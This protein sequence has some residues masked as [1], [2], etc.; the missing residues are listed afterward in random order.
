MLLSRISFK[1]RIQAL[2]VIVVIIASA[3]LTAFYLYQEKA[4]AAERA[5]YGSLTIKQAFNTI[6][7]DLEH[8]FVFRA[9]A[10][11]N[12]PEVKTYIKSR[13]NEEL[14]NFVL[15]RYTLLRN[16]NPYLKIMQF[17]AYDG[18][19]ILRMHRKNEFGDDIASKRPMLKEVHRTRKIH[20]EFEGGIEGI[21]YRIV[22]PVFDDTSY[23]GAI[24]FG[25]DTDYVVDKLKDITGADGVMMLHESRI[26]AADTKIYRKGIGAYRFTHYNDDKKILLK[27]YAVDNAQMKPRII[28]HNEKNYEINPIFLKDDR[29]REI[30]VILCIQDITGRYQNIS[31]TLIKSSLLTLMIIGVFLAFFEYV[32]GALISKIRFQDEYIRT[33]LN[34]Q[35]NIIVVSDGKNILFCN[36]A[37]LS[38]FKY[39][40]LEAFKKEHSCICDFFEASDAENYLQPSMDGEVWTD[41][42][43]HNTSQQ[44]KVKMSKEGKTSIFSAHAQMMVFEEKTLYVVVLTDITELNELA[45]LDALTRIPNRFHFNKVFEYSMNLSKRSGHPFSLIL[46]DIDHFKQV[47]D[48]YGHLAGDEILKSLSALVAKNIRKTDFIA[49]WGGEEFVILLPETDLSS[50]VKLA[51]MLRMKIEEHPFEIVQK[52]TC[53]MGVVQYNMFENEDGMMFR[54]DE[55]LYIAKEEGRNRIIAYK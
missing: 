53:S 5:E 55:N 8:F 35:K 9:N 27:E 6:V 33:I 47:N 32:F 30:G 3:I 18:R 25:V 39:E 11:M 43:V 23:I 10:I 13:Q 22:V 40:T 34:S 4:Y 21:A 45:T 48:Q 41:Y 17:H 50:A 36:Q 14:Y 37:F 44:H 28:T 52:I 24:E 2:I 51:D 42:L 26:G 19:S 29:G 12:F 1:Q 38:Y 54:A 20:A 16:E 49:R 31:D 7:G 15:P 46:F